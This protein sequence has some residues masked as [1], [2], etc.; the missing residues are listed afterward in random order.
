MR[1]RGRDDLVAG[2]H[3]HSDL[4]VVFQAE[5]R[6][7]G[8]PDGPGVFSDQDPDHRLPLN[9]RFAGPGAP[10]TV[11]GMLSTRSSLGHPRWPRNRRAARSCHAFC[12]GRTVHAS[13]QPDANATSRSCP[14]H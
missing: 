10:R 6:G 2:G 9:A 12:T 1:Q 11:T 8:L 14:R 3:R 5:Q 4:D 7:H 13:P